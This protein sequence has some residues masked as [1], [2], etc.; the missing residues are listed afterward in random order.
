MSISVSMLVVLFVTSI[1]LWTAWRCVR[2]I[3]RWCRPYQFENYVNDHPDLITGK[4][5]RCHACGGASIYITRVGHTPFTIRN[6]HICR[7]CG[8]TLYYSRAYVVKPHDKDR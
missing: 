7:R 1:T 2:W 8:E 5:V 4:S 3:R 6:A